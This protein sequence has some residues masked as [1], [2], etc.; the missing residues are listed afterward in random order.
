MGEVE[1]AVEAQ[2]AEMGPAAR[3]SGLGASAVVLARQ[4]DAADPDSRSIAG[5]A[6]ELRAT[7]DRLAVL[8]P[9]AEADDELSRLRARKERG[10]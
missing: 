8:Y 9:S 1:R 2:L 6:R 3:A 4:L 7:L 10:A 5:V